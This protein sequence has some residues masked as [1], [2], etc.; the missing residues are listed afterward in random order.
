MVRLS[1]VRIPSFQTPLFGTQLVVSPFPRSSSLIITDRQKNTWRR[2]EMDL[3]KGRNRRPVPTFC[4]TTWRRR[5]WWSPRSRWIAPSRSPPS[6]RSTSV[7]STAPSSDWACNKQPWLGM[8]N[9]SLKAKKMLTQRHAVAL[10]IW[11]GKDGFRSIVSKSPDLRY[12]NNQCITD[13]SR[14]M[15]YIMNAF[16]S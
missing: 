15:N 16:K 11:A 5:W 10:K 1:L 7:G 13:T 6:P 4:P 14:T 3:G 8:K 2:P 9:R 12:F